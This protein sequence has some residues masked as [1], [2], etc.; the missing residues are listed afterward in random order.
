MTE[1]MIYESPPHPSNQGYAYAKRMMGIQCTQYNET[2]GYNYICLIPVNLY[3]P[4]DNFNLKDSHFIPG[5]MHRWHLQKYNKDN[6]DNKEKYVLYGTG[7]PLRQF[8]YA[9]DF[10][11]LIFKALNSTT[12]TEQIRPK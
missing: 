1:E 2:Y 5:I 12:I 6:K 9:F 3:G 7:K 10:V 4:Y 8:I 11:K